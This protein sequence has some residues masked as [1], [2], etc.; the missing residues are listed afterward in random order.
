M[1]AKHSYTFL[2]FT[3]GRSSINGFAFVL[4]RSHVRIP[5]SQRYSFRRLRFTD[6]A[7]GN[8]GFAQHSV[9]STTPES[10]RQ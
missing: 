3:Y 4:Y 1:A 2:R 8:T 9:G 5:A 7:R 6:S 10:I